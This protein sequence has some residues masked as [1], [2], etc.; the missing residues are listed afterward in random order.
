MR[1]TV[2]HSGPVPADAT[3]SDA[4]PTSEERPTFEERLW[5]PVWLWVVGW[6]F[7]LSL[8]FSFYAALGPAWGL[9]LVVVPGALLTV[10]LASSAA[11]VRVA[12]GEL[13]A[14]PAHIEVRH[15]GP[16]EPLDPEA[17]RSIRGPASDPAAFHLIRGWVPTAVRADVVDPDDPTPYWYVATRR[18]RDL[19]AAV[20]R[21]RAGG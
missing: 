8:G 13:R 1:R 2:V 10:G 11:T 3:P 15:L 9:L 16:A 6:L 14:G 20:E 4:T 7:V 12:G 19:A 18:P 5:P 21:S 17:A